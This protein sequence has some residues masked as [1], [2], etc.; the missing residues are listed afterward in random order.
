MGGMTFR[1]STHRQTQ[2]LV[3]LIW[4]VACLV[5]WAWPEQAIVA[6][7]FVPDLPALP[8][9]VTYEPGN[10]PLFPWHPRHRW[11]KWAWR[12]YCALRRAHRRAIWTARLARL[13][14]T[15]ALTLAQVVDLLVRSQARRHLGA[16]P[17]LYALLETLQVGDIIN[18]HCPTR[19]QVKHGT[20]AL[21]LIL[22]RLTMP[23]PLYQIADWLG[24][25]A[26]VYGLGIPAAKFNDDRLARTLD[27]I[28]PYCREIWQGVVQRALVQAEIDLDLIFYDLTAYILHGEYRD[29]QYAEFGFAHNTPMNKRK[30]KNGLNVVADGNIPT[31]YAPWSGK[32]ADLATVQANMEQLRRFLAHRGWPIERV[33]VVGDRAN[34]NDELALAYDDRKIRYLAGLKTQKKVHRELLLAVPE[35]QFYSQPLTDDHGPRGYWGIPC[36]VS[37][38]HDDRHVTHRGLVVLSGPMRT[39]HRRGRAARLRELREALQEVQA[40]IG[41]PHYRTV[42]AVQKRAETQL[43]QSPVGKF[44]QAEAYEDENGQVRL[45]WWVNF[46]PLWQAMQPDGRYLLVTNDWNLSPRKMLALYRQKDGVEK[47]I[48]VSKQDLKV[49]PVYLHKDERIEAMLLINM[50]ALLAYSLLERQARQHGLQMTTRRIIAKLQ[51]LDVVETFCWDGSRL[52]RLAPVDEE[53]AAILQLLAEVL[54]ELQLLRSPHPLLSAGEN[55]LFALSPPERCQNVM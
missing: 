53:Q 26:L 27:A 2:I 50:L 45:R 47:R 31:E 17:V 30:F 24:R 40:K 35:E 16:L 39:A 21:V 33:M 34:L 38:E 48:Q 14:L 37:F 46:L 6:D 12:R 22:N 8:A 4:A 5:F 11:R 15:G 23:L 13:A 54:A 1:D 32:T 52:V 44:M 7:W 36:L 20:V 41:R 51:N 18:R 3:W 28:Q 43:R 49:S 55:T 9:V 42:K 10:G 19:A 25:T 29:S